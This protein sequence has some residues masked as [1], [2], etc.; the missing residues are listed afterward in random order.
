MEI[1]VMP[2]SILTSIYQA[3]AVDLTCM[4]HIRVQGSY[5][6]RVAHVNLSKVTFP[7]YY[8]RNFGKKV[9]TTIIEGELRMFRIRVIQIDVFQIVFL[10]FAK[11]TST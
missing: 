6:N 10:D 2:S 7:L 1:M 11:R 4:T 5:L 9:I 8:G 3:T